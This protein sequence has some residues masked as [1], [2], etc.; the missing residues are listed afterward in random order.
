MS[1]RNKQ[2]E[3]EALKDLRRRRDGLSKRI[4]DLSKS[5]SVRMLKA[6][7]QLSTL[8]DFLKIEN[9]NNKLS[10]KEQKLVDDIFMFQEQ[11]MGSFQIFQEILD[12]KGGTNG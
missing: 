10:E 7:T 12:Q 9:S 1:E 8:E 11:L 3:R 5:E 4:D 2:I 6:I